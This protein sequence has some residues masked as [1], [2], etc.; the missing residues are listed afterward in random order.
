[1][2]IISDFATKPPK[3]EAPL[4]LA[5]LI[6]ILILATCV[7][8]A[9]G[10]GIELPDHDAFATARGNAF[11]A[12]ADDPAAVYCNPAGISQLHGNNISLGAYGLVYGDQYKGAA[13]TINSR[14]EWR[15]TP[16]VFATFELP[17]HLT[18]GLGFYAPYGL[19][20]EWPTT[21][22]FSNIG[23]RGQVDYLTLNPVIAYEIIRGL[24]ISAGPTLNYSDAD[25]RQ[26]LYSPNALFPGSPLLTTHFHG[27]AEALGFNAGILWQPWEEH[28]FGVTYR[29]STDMNYKGHAD[30]PPPP[31]AS[32]AGTA[33]SADFKFPRSV[34]FGYSYRPTHRWNL[35]ADAEWMDW[36]TLNNLV[37]VGTSLPGKP[38]LQSIPFDWNS[39][40]IFK[41]GATRYFGDGWR[42][43]AG[44]MFVENSVPTDDVSP[45]IPDSDRHVFSVGIGKRYHNLSWDAAYQL[46]WG[47][48]RSVTGDA[49][50][51]GANGSYEFL[52]HAIT[53]NVGYHF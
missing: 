28:S 11:T 9:F 33:S 50:G 40:W 24:S 14:T 16:D 29:S 39:S 23:N 53:I 21:A 42:A 49:L 7:R 13:G 47:P 19:V 5:L 10:L 43:S 12:T 30:L 44:Y 22:P 18:A 1:M 15:A 31:F 41:L 4:G 25:L 35:E 26:Y 46:A 8:S 20:E 17:Y 2:S 38:V 45:L 27:D 34:S 3:H 32:G 6:A 37:L 48:S 52:S 51:A 36:A